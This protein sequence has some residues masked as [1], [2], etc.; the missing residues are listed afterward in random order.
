MAVTEGMFF[1][2][3]DRDVFTTVLR[4]VGETEENEKKGAKKGGRRK[5]LNTF[6]S[7]DSE[8][9]RGIFYRHSLQY[10]SKRSTYAVLST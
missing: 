3:A 6:R 1:V 9:D 7:Y 2:A 8:P 5:G 10:G 4:V